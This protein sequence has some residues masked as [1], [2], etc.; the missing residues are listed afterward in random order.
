VPGGWS[1]SSKTLNGPAIE[2]AVSGRSYR[3]ELTNQPRTEDEPSS[4]PPTRDARR[5]CVNYGPDAQTSPFPDWR[6]V[7]QWLRGLSD[8]QAGVTPAIAAAAAQIAGDA[9]APIEKVRRIAAFVQA[10]QYISIQTGIGRGGG[11]RPHAAADVLARRYGDCKDK[12]N[13][14]RTL[15]RAVG[16]ESVLVTAFLGDAA[17]VQ[18]AW[19]SPQQFNHCIL[20][21]RLAGADGGASIV[22]PRLGPLLIFDPTDPYTPP[23][24]LPASLHGSRVLLVADDP[25]PLLTLPAGD[26]SS[27]LEREVSAALSPAGQAAIEQRERAHGEEA[28]TRHAWTAELQPDVF[29]RQMERRVASLVPGAS[30][31]VIEATSD[32]A[33]ITFRYQVPQYGRTV[34]SLLVI[35]PVVARIDRLPDTTLPT[36]RR[37]LE[38]EAEASSETLRII[39]PRG[40]HVDEMPEAVHVES[41]LGEFIRSC[42]A[43]GNQ[44]VVTRTLRIAAAT[45]APADYARVREF[46]RQ[47]RAA[48]A[49]PVVLAAG[50]PPR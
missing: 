8:P 20:A 17:Y 5:L 28:A 34:G 14:M 38:I 25:D 45:V 26:L 23:G 49:A 2:P 11:Y 1:A 36:R 3:W 15:L 18:A 46:V 9:A 32:G 47:I 42:A 24:A 39:V 35:T 48:D 31:T 37:P 21:I 4:P 27:R 7:S 33:D 43:D 41:P 50:A 16:I 19:P 30:Q 29:A 22:H 44:V 12:A 13:L 6:S 10:L 40:Y